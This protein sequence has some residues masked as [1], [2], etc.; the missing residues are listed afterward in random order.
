MRGGEALGLL[1][2]AH[3]Q[4]LGADRKGPS[5]CGGW[6]APL[7][8]RKCGWFRCWGVSSLDPWGLGS[9]LSPHLTLD[10][11]P[12]CGAVPSQGESQL[13]VSLLDAAEHR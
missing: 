5:G 12:E 6:P 4:G 8:P 11:R 2:G 13:D 10:Q 3:L 1:G 9:L 7:S